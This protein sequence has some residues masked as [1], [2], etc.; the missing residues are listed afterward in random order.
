MTIPKHRVIAVAV[1]FLGI[2]LILFLRPWQGISNG[3]SDSSDARRG[4]TRVVES[5]IK[6]QGLVEP[7]RTKSG[8][9]AHQT[10]PTIEETNELYQTTIIPIIDLPPDQPLPVRIARI[11]ELIERA[12]VEPYRLRLIVRSAD[13][14]N[15]MRFKDEMRIRKIPL[16]IALKYLCDSTKL[17]YHIRKNGIIELTTLQEPEATSLVAG[18]EFSNGDP[19]ASQESDPFT[20]PRA[21]PFSEPAT[22]H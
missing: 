19:N 10:K 4:S 13:P 1:A 12:G 2:V 22:A 20:E 18:P 8:I 3:N 14:A 9:R 16:D 21:D 5:S 11:N 17:R 6:S 15:Q 7:I